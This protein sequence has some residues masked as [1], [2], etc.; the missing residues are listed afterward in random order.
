MKTITKTGAKKWLDAIIKVETTIQCIKADIPNMEKYGVEL[1]QYHNNNDKG[2]QLF[3]GLSA[4]A[5]VMG[6]ATESYLFVVRGEKW[7]QVSFK[8]NGYTFFEVHKVEE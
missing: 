5:G 2:I 3:S 1:C 4:V 7:S 6:I 8:Y